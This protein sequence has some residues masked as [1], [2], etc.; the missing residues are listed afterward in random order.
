VK[1]WSGL[2]FWTTTNVPLLPGGNGAVK[3]CAEL[4]LMFPTL[5]NDYLFEF[6]NDRARCLIS[7][8][9]K[10][11]FKELPRLLK[12]LYCGSSEYRSFEERMKKEAEKQ[13]CDPQDLEDS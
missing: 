11:R 7:L 4:V 6:F 12:S 13:D 8:P 10:E 9:G 2:W 5:P 3:E 1:N